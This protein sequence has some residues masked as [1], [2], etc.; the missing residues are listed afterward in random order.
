MPSVPRNAWEAVVSWGRPP[1][2]RPI[3][4]SLSYT[5]ALG[6]RPRSTRQARCPSSRS[7]LSRD[8][9]MRATIQRE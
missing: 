8:G 1:R 9:I 6:T 3:A 5:P 4:P 7:W 2:Q